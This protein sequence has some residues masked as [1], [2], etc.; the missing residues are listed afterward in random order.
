[1]IVIFD[2]KVDWVSIDVLVLTSDEL[3]FSSDVF[4][5]NGWLGDNALLNGGLDSFSYV[6]RLSGDTLGEDLGRGGHTL[7]DDSRFLLNFF[8]IS[9]VI[10]LES[11]LPPCGGISVVSLDYLLS[12]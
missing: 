8:D 1:M 9:F 12:A 11:L 4:I 10:R 2:G 7:C 6:S 5:H 3:G